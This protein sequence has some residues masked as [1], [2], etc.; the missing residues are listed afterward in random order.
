MELSRERAAKGAW[1]AL[2]VLG[3][4]HFLLATSG[5]GLFT[6]LDDAFMFTRYARHFLDGDG[7]SWNL[8]EGPAFG[9][10]SPA[11]LVLVT[12]TLGLTGWQDFEVLIWLSRAAG[13]AAMVASAWLGFVVQRASGRARS[14]SPLA[15]V[16]YLAFLTP[17]DY[18]GQSGMDTTLS[19]LANT[20]FAGAVVI[21]GRRRTSRAL[22]LCLA[23]GYFAFAARPDN[24]IY[25]ALLPPLYF[26]AAESR[27]W[28][29]SLR[30]PLF[31]A[32]ILAA[33]ALLKLR[34]FGDF[35]PLSYYV[36]KNGFYEG[37][38]GVVHW[39]PM[40][41]FLT[42]WIFAAPLLALTVVLAK[43]G[44]LLPLLA[45][46]APTAATLA[47]YGSMVQIMGF[48]ARYYF[49]SLAFVFLMTA[50]A[51]W[52]P[53]AAPATAT[54]QPTAPSQGV[55]AAGQDAAG[56]ALAQKGLLVRLAIALL[57]LLPLPSDTFKE[58]AVAWWRDHVLPSRQPI[59]PATV[60]SPPAGGVL[61]TLKGF[62]V[63]QLMSVLIGRMPP[64]TV[65]AASEHGFVGSRAPQV[66][67]V[68]LVGLHDRVLAHQ[69][70]SADYVLGRRP[71]L[72]WLPHAEYSGILARLLD[73]PE[74]QR[75]YELYPG[76]FLYGIALRRD[77]PRFA[78]VK[79][80][81]R[82]GF[83]AFYPDRTLE[84]QIALPPAGAGVL[85]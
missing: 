33:D 27:G 50:L 22:A 81:V 65:V 34:L 72:I 70:F 29:W 23:A 80:E 12:A 54:G 5:A 39:N 19:L 58:K 40:I 20:L 14:W 8:G 59:L 51:R 6:P 15:A 11:H 49:P 38:T 73:H 61:P 75:N 32:V 35:L 57:L 53:A 63:N 82:N 2:A 9:L 68:D 43:R 41:T 71:D 13:L 47:Y 56:R 31:L 4:G 18:H 85:R 48:E 3:L 7:F 10:T 76:A 1:A 77:S 46:A 67:I 30:Y 36:K 74:F 62:M 69:G 83:A 26:L 17:L 66:T 79:Q 25:V 55:A 84:A 44:H 16:P 28:K 24:L 52:P 42:F 45:V 37:Y 21:A 78:A 60:Y 64:G